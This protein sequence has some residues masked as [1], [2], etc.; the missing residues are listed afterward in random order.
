VETAAAAQNSA[1]LR[2]LEADRRQ[3][4]KR[5]GV[6]GR[7]RKSGKTNRPVIAQ[8]PFYGGGAWSRGLGGWWVLALGTMRLEEGRGA[9]RGGRTAGSAGNGL[10]PTGGGSGACTHGTAP[11]RGGGDRWPVGPATVL[12]YDRLN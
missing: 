12:G 10:M 2:S 4:G 11:N 9:W 5:G 8:H 3:R 7:S 1:A 6:R